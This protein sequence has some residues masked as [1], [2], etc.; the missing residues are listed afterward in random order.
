[1]TVLHV[2]DSPLISRFPSVPFHS[3]FPDTFEVVRSRSKLENLLVARQIPSST[4]SSR[5]TIIEGNVK[6]PAPV[7]EALSPRNTTVDIVISAIGGTMVFGSNPLR[8]TLDDP[9][10]CQDAISTILSVLRGMPG[11]KPLLAV[12]STTGISDRV[13]DVPLAMIPLYHWVLRVPHEDK[14]KMESLVVG[15]MGRPA[16]QRAIKSFVAVRPSL[17][18]NGPRLGLKK[19]RVGAEDGREGKP[20]V[21]YTISRADA[22]GWIFDEIIKGWDR[23]RVQWEG[24]MVSITY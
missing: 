3:P 2:R 23:G 19:L 14:K 21:G 24:K 11:P 12:L 4:I 20:A 8:A 22:G 5:L 18:T 7:A 10:I 13:R 9:T 6:D 1:M 16:E 15:E 17:F